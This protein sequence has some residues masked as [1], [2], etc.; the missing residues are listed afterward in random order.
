M[1]GLNP[2][3]PVG[4][5]H[6]LLSVDYSGL[7]KDLIVEMVYKCD[8]WDTCYLEK[9]LSSWKKKKKQPY[10]LLPLQH[11]CLPSHIKEV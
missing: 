1:F 6:L 2:G 3:F 10:L 8:P 4:F 7:K 9:Y 5:F 11:A